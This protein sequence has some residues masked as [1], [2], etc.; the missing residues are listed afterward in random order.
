MDSGDTSPVSLSPPQTSQTFWMIFHKLPHDSVT[1][2]LC[3]KLMETHLN[4]ARQDLH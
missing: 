1:S 4:K 2:F 3:V